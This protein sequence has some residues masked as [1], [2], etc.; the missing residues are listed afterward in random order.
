MTEVKLGPGKHALIGYGSLLSIASMERT[1]G[2]RYDGPWHVCRLN[3]WRR[4]WDVQ[5]PRH[6]W[7]YRVNGVLVKPARVLYLNLRRQEGSHV[8]VALFVVGD[9]DLKRFDEREWIYERLEVT[10]DLADV[11]VIGGAAWTYVA[12][13]AFLWRKDSRPPAAIIRRSY[14]DILATAHAELGPAFRDEYNATTDEVPAHLVVD[15][16]RET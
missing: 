16:E 12:L 9:D 14:L 6:A 7:A 3:G 4:G 15:D 13:D 11:R 1:L 5:M 8:N 2:R 10:G